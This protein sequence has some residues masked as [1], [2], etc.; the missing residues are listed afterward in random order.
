MSRP[1]FNSWKP[2]TV[3]SVKFAPNAD[4]DDK[5]TPPVKTNQN[6]GVVNRTPSVSERI[7][8]Q[9][10]AIKQA[11]LEG[12]EVTPP[13]SPKSN[14]PKV[15]DITHS[16]EPLEKELPPLDKGKEKEIDPEAP[17]A[18]PKIQL[19][20]EDPPIVL[21]GVAL[22]NGEMGA[23]L[24]KAKSE[25]PLRAIRFPII[26]EYQNCFS[27]LEFVA[28]LQDNVKG[29]EDNVDKAELFA[30]DLT[31]RENAL[32]RLGELGMFLILKVQLRWN[33]FDRKSLW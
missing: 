22:T 19:P 33:C 6:H 29:L 25:L 13:A 15:I 4:Y 20:P 28:W 5:F 9:I 30:R 12:K 32:R 10:S 8:K 17:V 24:E 31:E 3:D 16:P 2:L 21:A 26:G 1:P 14:A 11:A 27:G 18:L 7:S 23:L